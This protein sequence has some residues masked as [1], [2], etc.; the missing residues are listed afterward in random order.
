MTFEL[1]YKW[2]KNLLFIIIFMVLVVW[3][4]LAYFWIE[5]IK[6]KTRLD[7]RQRMENLMW[8]FKDSVNNNII[9][10][11]KT[12]IHKLDSVNYVLYLRN[13]ALEKPVKK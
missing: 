10:D 3:S 1:T 9:V 12:I 2:Q 7:E 8:E 6:I 13:N 11:L 4:I 5:N